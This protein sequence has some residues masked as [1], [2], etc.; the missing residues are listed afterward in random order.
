MSA[1]CVK[2]LMRH[3]CNKRRMRCLYLAKVSRPYQGLICLHVALD[4]ITMSLRV[5]SNRWQKERT[6]FHSSLAASKADR[7]EER[8]GGALPNQYNGSMSMQAI[9]HLQASGIC[10]TLA[11]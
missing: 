2:G 9:M 1:L 6:A 4:V 7:M 10:G 8:L 5:Q 3:W 11:T